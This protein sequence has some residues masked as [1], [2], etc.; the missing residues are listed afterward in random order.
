MTRIFQFWNIRFLS[1]CF[2][3]L[4]SRERKIDLNIP[5]DPDFHKYMGS[6]LEKIEKENQNGKIN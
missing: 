3:V 5:K 4:T 6:K 2:F 1:R